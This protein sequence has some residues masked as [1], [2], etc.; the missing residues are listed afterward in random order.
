MILQLLA[1][2]GVDDVHL[3]IADGAAPAHDRGGDE[4]DGGLEH[5]RRLLPGPL[6]QPR[7]RGPGRHASTLGHD[8]ARRDGDH[9]PPRRRDATCSSTSTSTSCR[10]TA[11]TSRSAPACRNY[12][13]AEGAP[14]APPHPRQPT[15]TWIPTRS[16]LHRSVERIGRV[17]DKHLNVFHIETTINNRMFDG[18]LDFLMKNEDDF[19]E[20]DRL[21]LARDASRALKGC[22]AAAKRKIFQAV[23]AAYEVI[24]VARRRAPSRPT[25][26]SS[27]AAGSSTRCDVDG[28][29]D[30][31]H[32]RD[33]VHLALQRQ[34]DP[35]PAA[36][37][38]DGAGATSSTSTGASRC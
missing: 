3:I 15:R 5:L 16:E 18:P 9:Q 31:R 32:L 12:E 27:S 2:S 4:A 26:R 30:M 13:S 8:R 24:A 25:P 21:K 14:H 1:D 10:W 6:L 35:E 33:P 29:A 11:G 20:L 28:Q 17:I 23:P 38:G 7:R 34:L 37:A 36:G 19:T 22:R